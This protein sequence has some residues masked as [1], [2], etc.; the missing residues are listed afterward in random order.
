MQYSIYHSNIYAL[1]PSNNCLGNNAI[2]TAHFCL[3]MDKYFDS[4]NRSTIKSSN[5]KIL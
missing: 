4:I 1:D 3:F 2:G 5:G